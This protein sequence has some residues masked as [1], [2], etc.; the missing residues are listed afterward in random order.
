MESCQRLLMTISL[1]FMAAHIVKLYP[2]HKGVQV[3]DTS[4]FTDGLHGNALT[5]HMNPVQVA[6]MCSGGKLPQKPEILASIIGI[7]LFGP[8]NLPEKTMHSLF[9][10]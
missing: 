1:Y 2:K 4:L 3:W 6:E 9:S 5:Y 7:T 10:I 8:C